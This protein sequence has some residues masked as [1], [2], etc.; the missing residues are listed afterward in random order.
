MAMN[1]IGIAK[2]LSCLVQFDINARHAYGQVLSLISSSPIRDHM[3]RFQI[4]QERHVSQLSAMMRAFDV[5]PPDRVRD[6]RGFILDRFLAFG[7]S[8]GIAYILLA[9]KTNEELTNQIYRHSSQLDLS[10]SIKE[11][12]SR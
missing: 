5:A 2:E 8:S 1:N 3:I 6:L 7:G 11:L 4:D 10:P 12:F 9:M